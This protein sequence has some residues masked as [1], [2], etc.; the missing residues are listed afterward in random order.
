MLLLA[1]YIVRFVPQASWFGP[2]V[3]G[4]LTPVLY[5]HGYRVYQWQ[6]HVAGEQEVYLLTTVLRLFT[7]TLLQDMANACSLIAQD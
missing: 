4:R 5:H 3:S 7:R 6:W 2:Q 1:G